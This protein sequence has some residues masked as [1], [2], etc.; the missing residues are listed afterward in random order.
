MTRVLNIYPTLRYS[1]SAITSGIQY[2]EFVKVASGARKCPC[3]LYDPSNASLCQ[4]FTGQGVFPCAPYKTSKYSATLRLCGLRTSVEPQAILD[5]IYSL[6]L[7][8][9]SYPQAVDAIKMLRVR[10]IIE[11][12]SS[13]S[14]S[15]LGS[16]S[17]SKIQ[18]G[19]VPFSTALTII[20]VHPQ[21]LVASSS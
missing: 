2:L 11:Y 16:Y 18:R 6:S 12:V 5:L 8:A 13:T 9:K 19:Y 21:K 10:A 4:I 14:F 20:I 15:A 17:V 3:D 7:Q 1:N